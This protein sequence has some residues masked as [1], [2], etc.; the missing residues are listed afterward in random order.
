MLL[1]DL[2]I[3]QVAKNGFIKSKSFILIQKHSNVIVSAAERVN[4]GAI[5]VLH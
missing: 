5:F 2:L 1:F 3:Q 4:L